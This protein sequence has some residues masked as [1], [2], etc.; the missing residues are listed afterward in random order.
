MER[1]RWRESVRETSAVQLSMFTLNPSRTHSHCHTQPPKGACKLGS[2]F[3][4][5]RMEEKSTATHTTTNPHTCMC[6]VLLKH[7][8]LI[9]QVAFCH[10][11]I[12]QCP[13]LSSSLISPADGG[14]GAAWRGT[15]GKGF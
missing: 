2:V 11:S 9:L 7:S 6:N 10:H 13:V 1:Q 3:V 15:C 5:H 14:V 12:F 4:S 8:F